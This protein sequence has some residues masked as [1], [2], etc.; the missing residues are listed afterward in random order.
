MPQTNDVPALNTRRETTIFGF[1]IHLYEENGRF[2]FN[3][4][5]HRSLAPPAL[6]TRRETTNSIPKILLRN[7]IIICHF[8]FQILKSSIRSFGVLNFNHSPA[9]R[10]RAFREILVLAEINVSV[11]LLSSSVAARGKKDGD[12]E[13]SDDFHNKEPL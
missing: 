4:Q 8:F 1:L 3:N 10:R 11:I 7:P 6:N 5:C 2:A 12:R 9:R 13:L